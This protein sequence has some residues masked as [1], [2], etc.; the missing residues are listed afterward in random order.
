VSNAHAHAHAYAYVGDTRTP[1]TETHD[2][3]LR[4]GD[5]I[6]SSPFAGNPQ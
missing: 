2:V 6:R 1:T 3:P 4:R 5:H